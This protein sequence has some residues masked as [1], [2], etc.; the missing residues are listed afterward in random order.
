MEEVG[1]GRIGVQGGGGAWT[2]PDVPWIKLLLLIPLLV[3]YQ[4]NMSPLDYV[5][6]I[7]QTGGGS[8]FSNLSAMMPVIRDAAGSGGG[9]GGL[10]QRSHPASPRASLMLSSGP[11]LGPAGGSGKALGTSS[12]SGGALNGTSPRASSALPLVVISAPPPCTTELPLSAVDSASG[13]STSFL[14]H[15]VHTIRLRSSTSWSQRGGA[16]GTAEASEYLPRPIVEMT[17]LRMSPSSSNQA[18]QPMGSGSGSG[19]HAYIMSGSDGSILG[20]RSMGRHTRFAPPN[21]GGSTAAQ[22]GTTTTGSGGR[23]SWLLETAGG[24]RG[25]GGGAVSGGGGGSGAFD[26][27]LESR[28]TPRSILQLQGGTPPLTPSEIIA[29]QAARKLKKGKLM[30]WVWTPWVWTAASTQARLSPD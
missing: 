10:G 15:E 21:A 9:G 22:G 24:S 3:G 25:S 7:L 17:E 28:N 14:L 6:S 30:S 8:S 4:A 13:G 23:G 11:V 20:S 16:A 19:G 5:P 18:L 27:D 12:G 29:H 2:P 26:L 1:P